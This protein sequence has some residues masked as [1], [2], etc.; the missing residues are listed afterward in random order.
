MK[1]ELKEDFEVTEK[2]TH[3][4]L[5]CYKV[6]D[7]KGIER[8]SNFIDLKFVRGS[9]LKDED[10]EKREGTLHEHLIS[11]MISDLQFKDSLVPSREGALVITSLQN[12][13]NWMRQRQIDRIKRSVVG[14][15]K[16]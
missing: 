9:K 11:A 10:V 6:V 12:A 5:P 13:L 14:T 4:K 15:Y 3:Y 1:I 8:T 7:G 2:G 16:K